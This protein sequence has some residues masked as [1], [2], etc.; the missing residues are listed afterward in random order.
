M[1]VS[2]ISR[3]KA[4]LSDNLRLVQAGET[5]EVTDRNRPI[6]RIV[7]VEGGGL[8]DRPAAGPFAPVKPFQYPEANI[9]AQGLLAAERGER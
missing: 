9:D 3:L 7:P 6:A 4:H 2:N 1:I 5:V 8:V